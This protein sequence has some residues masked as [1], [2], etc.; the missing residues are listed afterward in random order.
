MLTEF[1]NFFPAEEIPQ[2]FP[3]QE[4]AIKSLLSR[5]NTL[6]IVP[7]GGGKSL[8][9]YLSGLKLGNTTLVISPL[10]ALMQEQVNYLLS[11]GINAISFTSDIGFQ[12]QR[13]ILRNLGYS[14]YQFIYVSPERL[15]DFY[16]KASFLQ[17]KRNVDLVVVDEAHCI[18]QWGHDFRPEYGEIPQFIKFLTSNGQSP[19][20]LALTATLS[21]KAIDD[22]KAEFGIESNVFFS[23]QNLVRQE[24]KLSYHE[25][26][27]K[28]EKEEKWSLMIDFLKNNKSR[29]ALIYFY[30]KRK[31]EELSARF[32]SEKP[33]GGLRGDFFH[34]DLTE[35]EKKSKYDQFKSGEISVLFTTTAFGMGMNIPDIDA[36]IQYHLPK[37][38]EEYYQQVGRGAREKN[39]CPYCNC[40]LFWSEKNIA[41]NVRDQE[42]KRFDTDKILEGIEH[43]AS[44]KG[45][46]K[47]S[48]ISFSTLKNAKIDVSVLRYYLERLGL[49]EIIG[50]INGGPE[51]IRFKQDTARWLE[52]KAAAIGNSLIIASKKLKTEVQD[53]INYIYS[54][55]LAG[56]IEYL[57][58]MEKKLF[59][60]TYFDDIP[61]DK[62]EEIILDNDKRIDYQLER[63]HEL[64]NLIKSPDPYVYL[65][66]V[67]K[68]V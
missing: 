3:Y 59:I 18:S 9:Y 46:G 33:L 13:K 11:K 4:K 61:A 54:Q 36:V 56:N 17:S 26:T 15:Q 24:L 43:L 64:V 8:V 62:V 65:R 67:F 25:I 63:F 19:S 20:V 7:T 44:N 48:S 6:T 10:K 37:S 27:A 45:V 16:F 55:D 31:C 2:L 42:S 51:S 22:I 40:L 60:K 14:N 49:I 68:E 52:I 34:A 12:D 23:H 57:P 5:N 58:A 35:R 66:N 38:V 47:I 41:A 50:E 30:S 53:L 1:R 32:A 28:P 21:E 29:K 39:L